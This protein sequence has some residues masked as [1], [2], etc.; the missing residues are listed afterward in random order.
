MTNREAAV[1]WVL[2]Y[3]AALSAFVARIVYLLGVVTIDP[4]PEP[5]A[6]QQWQRKRRWLV[7]SEFAAL[8]MFATL[9]V[10]AVAQGWL[11]PVAAVIAA[12]VSGAL[13][14]AFFVHALETV[15]RN[16]LNVKGAQ[17]AER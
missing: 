14:F 10:L 2:A 9:S 1:L 4:P 11:S 3:G 8:P 7:A 15:V 17:H 12:L 16:R 5:Q 6:V 13:G